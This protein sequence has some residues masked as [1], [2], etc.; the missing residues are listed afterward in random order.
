MSFESL[1]LSWYCGVFIIVATLIFPLGSLRSWA[2]AIGV[3]L[4]ISTSFV[5]AGDYL[6]FYS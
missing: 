6:V 1:L 2:L 3:G 4:M 5:L